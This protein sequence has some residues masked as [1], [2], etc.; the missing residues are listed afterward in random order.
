MKKNIKKTVATLLV[1]SSII[2]MIGCK[3]E[4]ESVSKSEKDNTPKLNIKD[5][6]SVEFSGFDGHGDADLKIDDKAIDD[7]VDAEKFS[8]YIE[9]YLTSTYLKG[10]TLSKTIDIDFKEIYSNLS[11][12][13]TVIVIVS[14]PETLKAQ[15]V[16]FEK[17]SEGIDLKVEA[18]EIPFTVSG[19]KEGEVID[20]SSFIA[21]N[22]KYD[23]ANGGISPRVEF[24]QDFTCQ[25]GNFYLR[26]NETF[27]NMLDIIYENKKIGSLTYYCSKDKLSRND[28]FYIS[29][30]TGGYSYSQLA[31]ILA[32][33]NYVFPSMSVEFVVPNDVN[34]YVNKKE[35]LT[36]DV[37][38]QLDTLLSN[39][40]QK[41]IY[42]VDAEIIESYIAT[43]KPGG[44]SNLASNS[45]V[46]SIIKRTETGYFSRGTVY[47]V[48]PAYDVMI[49]VDGKIE[50]T[51]YD[52]NFDTY[53]IDVSIPKVFYN[54]PLVPPIGYGK[55]TQNG[56]DIFLIYAPDYYDIS[57]KV[58][59]SIFYTIH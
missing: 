38:E 59:S 47:T 56:T 22:I 53:A 30:E 42:Y 54:A 1:L 16:T 48:A 51:Y 9:P 31:E 34:D 5:C 14:L 27:K 2:L 45:Y 17:L 46:L 20:I 18:V 3:S 8:K 4:G 23:G 26:T 40:I 7:Q 13:D 29:I 49:T 33:E 28:K 58:Y 25:R 24:A 10:I 52:Y 43:V 41:N 44:I 19:L 36:K 6:I 15:G 12:G 32:G 55:A 11:N 21:E 57:N 35:Q 37:V 50:A 39:E